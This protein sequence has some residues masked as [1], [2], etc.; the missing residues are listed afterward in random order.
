MAVS[1][2][3][4][5]ALRQCAKIMLPSTI[6]ETIGKLRRTAMVFKPV[7]RSQKRPVRTDNWREKS[8]IEYVRR[9][10]ER[11]DPEYSDVFSIFNKITESSCEKLSN[12]VIALIQKRDEG[13]RLRVC[14]LLFDKAITNH[15][16]ASVMADCAAILQKNIPEVVD[17]M[18][19]QISMF[20]T[21]Y[22]MN[23]T[24]TNDNIIEW[25]RQKE[26]RRGYAKFV[27]ELYIR[28]LISDE[29]V[30]KGLFD[31]FTELVSL[32]SEAKTP[33]VEE[34][35]H[36]CA[37]F[38]FETVKLIPTTNIQ[39]RNLVRTTITD[40]LLSNPSSFSM[41]T[42]WKLEDALKMVS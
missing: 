25:T 38:L 16:F 29:C 9:V 31:V 42:K 33:Q 19:I 21:L 8:L 30:E 36:Q 24:V 10:K 20:D 1:V 2:A 34:N 28:Q 6:E 18:G 23:D 11:E 7:Y 3:D 41:K 17:D 5:Y 37:V 40:I 4:M 14:T 32:L 13:F 22:N 27:T 35:I 12:D 15:M 26:K 39:S